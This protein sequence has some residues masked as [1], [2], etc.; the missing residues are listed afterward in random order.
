MQADA[1]DALAARAASGERDALE[2]LLAQIVDGGLARAPVRRL[3]I[4][5]AEAADVEQDVLI[6]VA[7]SIGGFRG[8]ARFTTW[9]HRVARNTAVDHLRRRRDA[10]PLDPEVQGPTERISSLI[11]SR[12]VLED[13]LAALPEAYREPVVLR[14]VAQLPYAEIAE[15]L[16]LN[17][18]TV[19]TRIARGRALVAA[20]LEP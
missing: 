5:E 15:R 17:L 18:N 11:A 4:E 12:T 19:K 7:E 1:L 6:A 20:M 9:L 10:L 8:E 14:D 13:A 16:D 3:I 2:A